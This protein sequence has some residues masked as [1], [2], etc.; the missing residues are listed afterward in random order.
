MKKLL[1]Y[2]LSFLI[3]LTSTTQPAIAA[4]NLDMPTMQKVE[5]A[6]STGMQGG[7]A[8]KAGTGYQQVND[9]AISETVA[10]AIKEGELLIRLPER[11]YWAEVPSV[12]VD[13][14]DLK[15]DD[16]NLNPEGNILIVNVSDASTSRSTIRIT[17]IKLTAYR[18]ITEG[19]I[20]VKIGG[21]AVNQTYYNGEFKAWTILEVGIGDCIT[22]APAEEKRKVTINLVNNT[23]LIN[24]ENCVLEPVTYVENGYIYLALGSASEVF[25]ITKQNIVWDP[26]TNTAT[27]I[28]EGTLVQMTI[29]NRYMNINGVMVPMD[30][31]PRVVGEQM[32]IPLRWIAL[33]FGADVDY[34]IE[35]QTIT[36]N[37]D[38]A[39]Q[40]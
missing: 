22:P 40:N 35:N 9:I 16:V 8:I 1:L 11:V 33:A 39:R 27:L 13:I 21:P 4:E 3:T 37:I 29:G 25:G 36:L 2:T 23:C 34:D 17:G 5:K 15:I 6:Y 30:V 19:K 12:T 32:M 18:D 31:A 7:N 14:G 24:D 10:G 28:K 26:E 20:E 38:L